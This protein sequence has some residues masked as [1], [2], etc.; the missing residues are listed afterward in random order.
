MY[1]HIIPSTIKC[2]AFSL[3]LLPLFL[4]SCQD[5]NDIGASIRP[6]EDIMNVK[7]KSFVVQTKTVPAG[8]IYSE[9]T[10]PVLGYYTDNVFGNFQVDFL[11]EFRYVRNLKF[12]SNAESDSLYLVMYYKNFFGDAD[13]VQEA[14]VYQLD[15]KPLDFSTN[16]YSDID[17]NEFCTKQIVLGKRTYTAFDKTV[18]DNERALSGYCNSVRIRMPDELKHN[19]MTRTDIYASQ[20]EFVKFLKGVY[21]T[22][23]FGQQTVLEID[24]VNLELN[25]HF[26]EHLTAVSGA[27]SVVTR[28]KKVLFPSNKET[29]E[30]VRVVSGIKEE[31]LALIPDSV[32]CVF[33]PG[34]MFV[35]VEIPFE[36][37]YNEV[38]ASNIGVNDSLININDFSLVMQEAETG[39]NSLRVTTP[40]YFI[41]MR[42]ADMNEFFV[43]SLY[44]APNINTVIGTYSATNGG[45]LFNNAGN[46]MEVI[47]DSAMKMTP[48]ART[49]Y[50]KKMNPY[51][52]VP[53]SGLTDVAGTNATVRHLFSTYGT[54]VRSGRNK[55][56]PMRISITYTNL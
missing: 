38:V 24:S 36:E 16:Y 31:D 49:E 28:Y 53:V 18:P 4:V 54:M 35:Q 3:A 8:S 33:S 5:I 15:K 25:Y 41:F 9:T 47:L 14:T 37:I 12:E 20:D 6:F 48:A 27:D 46:F 17:V 23:T 55:Y 45:Y 13:A 30:V 32:E 21:V 39:Y 40:I 42:K 7:K 11:T 34:G 22:N 19:L 26:V 29:T 52:I 44:P 50:F 56:S 2:L 43:Q 10:K 51:M 1:K